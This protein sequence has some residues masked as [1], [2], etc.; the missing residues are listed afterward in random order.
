MGCQ[1]P[2]LCRNLQLILSALIC[3]GVSAITC[4]AYSGLD[5]NR[6]QKV[7]SP[8]RLWYK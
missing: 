5:L 8:S 1:R 2:W 7:S 4:A 3:L 6:A